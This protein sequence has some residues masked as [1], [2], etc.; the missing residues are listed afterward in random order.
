VWAEA[1]DLFQPTSHIYYMV[2]GMIGR[3][4]T[5][6]ALWL[7]SISSLY[8]LNSSYYEAVAGGYTFP[9]QFPPRRRLT[10]AGTGGG[11]GLA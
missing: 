9:R 7:T 2:T 11:L 1:L 4:L 8:Q 6:E 10:M 3:Q 5:L